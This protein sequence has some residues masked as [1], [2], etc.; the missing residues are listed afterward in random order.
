MSYWNKVN[1]K[2]ML[3][4][5]WLADQVGNI[6]LEAVNSDWAATVF[7]KWDFCGVVT[8]TVRD[9]FSTTSMLLNHY[10]TSNLFLQIVLHLYD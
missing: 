5:N 3:P 4:T 8:V 9:L 1:K 10:G 6:F 2:Q 7:S